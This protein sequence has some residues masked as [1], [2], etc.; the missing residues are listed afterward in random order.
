MSLFVAITSLTPDKSVNTIA[1]CTIWCILLTGTLIDKRGNRRSH[2]P[3]RFIAQWR[4]ISGSHLEK[5]VIDLKGYD[6]SE[7]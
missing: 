1:A 2:C 3:I 6:P 5:Q 4:F 7:W